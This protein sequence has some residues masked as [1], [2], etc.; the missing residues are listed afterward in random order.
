MRQ[1]S[2]SADVRS[3]DDVI[4]SEGPLDPTQLEACDPR[5]DAY[6]DGVTRQW[7]YRTGRALLL[8]PGLFVESDS[9]PAIAS[10]ARQQK[11]KWRFK[12]IVL[13]VQALA[14]FQ[15]NLKDAFS[16]TSKANLERTMS[17]SP[18]SQPVP[19]SAAK[20]QLVGA[21][22]MLAIALVR[23]EPLGVLLSAPTCKLLLGGADAVCWED[24]AA[25]LPAKRF[26]AVL[27]CMADDVSE[28]ERQSRLDVF[29][30]DVL[31]LF[32]WDENPLFEVASRASRRYEVAVK[33]K[34]KLQ[35]IADDAGRVEGLK[36]EVAAA[37]EKLAAANM[38]L[39]KVT[40]ALEEGQ[41]QDHEHEHEHEREREHERR[42]MFAGAVA[43]TSTA[44]RFDQ[45]MRAVSALIAAKSVPTSPVEGAK[46]ALEWMASSA[47]K[48]R[49]GENHSSSDI[50]V[51]SRNNAAELLQQ[52]AECKTA[53]LVATENVT[54]AKTVL[55][56][57]I[58]RVGAAAAA[59]P[60][61]AAAAAA[62]A[63]ANVPRA[64]SRFDSAIDN[65]MGDTAV[66]DQSNVGDYIRGW[67]KKELV[68]NTTQQMKLM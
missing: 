62:D 17:V 58:R 34:G 41:K 37:V 26:G 38:K 25:V 46:F 64:P 6:G 20:K 32:E 12:S 59:A 67:A 65:E 3:S 45:C 29:K 35:D 22:R 66:V 63:A 52:V 31:G 68:V 54:R 19:G 53:V 61:V 1:P 44:S 2:A 7:V 4:H 23:K 9:F 10:D 36:A 56:G 28:S 15:V 21:G 11:K 48:D 43:G 14:K 50:D 13:V 57:I 18:L 55:G 40:L 16:Q 24:L 33:Q 51:Q 8:S 42:I 27:S 49:A 30:Q 5:D 47:K 60:D 39:E